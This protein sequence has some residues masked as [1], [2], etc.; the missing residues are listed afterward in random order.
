MKIKSTV[1][2]VMMSVGIL[3]PA[4]T[5]QAQTTTVQAQT[6]APQGQMYEDAE[7][8]AQG[9]LFHDKDHYIAYMYAYANDVS[10]SSF[11]INM[12]LDGSLFITNMNI[13]STNIPLPQPLGGIPVPASGYKNVQV[14][15]FAVDKYGNTASTG[16]FYTNYLAQGTTISMSMTPQFP[17]VAIQL[18]KGLDPSTITMSLSGASG[19]WGWSYDPSTGLFTIDLYDLNTTDISYSI[20]DNNGGLLAHGSLPFFQ[21]LPGAGTDTNSVFDMHNDGNIVILPLGSNGYNYVNSAAFDSTVQ[22]N[23]QYIP[24]KVIGIPD[25]GNR[26]LHVYSYGLNDG[27]IEVR[28]WSATGTMDIVPCI[29]TTDSYGDVTAITSD[30]VDRVVVTVLPGKNTGKSIG[31]YLG[32]Y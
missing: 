23:D 17:P 26:K 9:F 19:G 25:V 13:N 16:Q 4:T 15:I 28:K 8:L 5:I 18:Q 27:T 10:S 22:R 11:S 32:T 31:L 2:A 12:V 24:A 14:Q 30:Y 29:T 6:P 3:L 7:L 20:T 1:I 21:S